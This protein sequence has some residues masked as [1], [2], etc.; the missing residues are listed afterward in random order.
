MIEGDSLHQLTLLDDQSVDAVV[1][2]PPYGINFQG[3]RWDGRAIRD[4]AKR[5]SPDR[6]LS[7]GEAFE[8]WTREWGQECLRVLK[9]GA[10]L[11]AFGS[12][13]TWHR[14]ATGLE[15]SGLELRDTLMWL[16]GTGMPKSRR[17]PNGT[18]TALK[19]AWEPILLCRRSPAGTIEHAVEQYGTGVLNIDGTRVDGLWPANLTLTHS[20]ACDENGCAGD[21][22]V[23]AVDITADRSRAP[24]GPRAQVSRLFYSPKVSRRERDAGCE[25]LPAQEL[26]LFPRAQGR[27]P[28]AARNAHPTVKPIAL[29]RWLVRL[30]APP[31]GLVLDPFCGSGSTGI[32]AV[33][34]DRQFVGIE[35]EPSYVKIARARISHWTATGQENPGR[36]LGPS[37]RR[38]RRG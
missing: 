7:S 2:D 36:P 8:A 12:P 3:E 20:P 24:S 28:A 25:A 18:G 16:Y 15:D 38:R 6:R 11:L 19:P 26:N 9:P 34:E 33:L 32:A 10:L 17:L 1:C 27:T 22:P 13:R 37:N 30:V 4:T 35:R 21:C 5:S 29:M 23:Q 14:L 31:D